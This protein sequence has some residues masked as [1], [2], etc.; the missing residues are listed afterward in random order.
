MN[1]RNCTSQD[2]DLWVRMNLD[3]MAFD[4]DDSDFWNH[5]D[6]A[7]LKEGLHR[8]FREALLQPELIT[9]LFL[10]EEGE[11]VG[12]AN[13]MT[14]FSVWALGKALYLDDLYLIERVRGKGLGRSFMEYLEHYCRDHDYHRLQFQS[15]PTNTGA[16][17]FYKNL[18][19]RSQD[20]HFY[21]KT[22][23]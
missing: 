23:M 7:V 2:E 4:M 17:A 13:L 22:L 1:I 19:Y 14:I 6:E 12:F 5:P 11:V 15:E 16:H 21:V 3:F 8:T 9:L 18:G 10:E 20:M